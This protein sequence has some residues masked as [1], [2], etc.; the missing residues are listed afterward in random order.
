MLQVLEIK[1]QRDCQQSLQVFFDG[2]SAANIEH[3][4]DKNE[5]A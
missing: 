5:E 3:V 4:V 1:N 2:I